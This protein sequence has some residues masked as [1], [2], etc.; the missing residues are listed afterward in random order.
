MTILFYTV[1]ELTK[2]VCDEAVYKLALFHFFLHT[3]CPVGCHLPTKMTVIFDTDDVMRICFWQKKRVFFVKILSYMKTPD[4]K[5]AGCF[6]S[7]HVFIKGVS[8]SLIFIQIVEKG[9]LL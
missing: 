7:H 3:S 2:H 1:L 8:K 5:I 9:S 4:K 6:F